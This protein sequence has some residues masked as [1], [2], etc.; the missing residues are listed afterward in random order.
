MP[1]DDFDPNV[2]A[3]LEKSYDYIIAKIP[4]D[5][6]TLMHN[7]EEMGFRYL[8]NQQ[9]IYFLANQMQSISDKWID[10]FN[11]IKCEQVTDKVRL[12][13]IC[14]HIR[15]GLYLKGRISSDPQLHQG[16][17]DL[18]IIN[19]LHDLFLR[20]GVSIWELRKGNDTIGYFALEQACGSALNIV[21]AGIFREFQNKGFSFSILLNVLKIAQQGN[22]QG[23]F[24]SISTGNFNTL[25]SISRF[26]NF[27]VKETYVVAR[28]ITDHSR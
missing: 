22:Y 26:V 11:K 8:E 2:L 7:L 20:A 24:S 16:I 1:G 28:K 3:E 12:D 15:K 5:S 27:S 18:R 14:E 4:G 13:I 25:N 21:Q 10:R 23:I 9:V 19:W 6:I 17:S